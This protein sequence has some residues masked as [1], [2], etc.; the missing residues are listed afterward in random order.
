MSPIERRIALWLVK[1]R[2]V[3]ALLSVLVVLLSASGARFLYLDTDYKIF[4]SEENPYR[5]AH[6]YI[7]DTYV[8]NQDVMF[9]IVPRNGQVFTKQS[10][11]LIEQLTAD[12]WTLP[13][14]SRVNSVTNFQHTAA[15]GD[16]LL[17]NYLVEDAHLLTPEDITRVGEIANSEKS[18][19]NVL[20]AKDHS[21]SGVNV[22]F[23][24]PDSSVKGDDWSSWEGFKARLFQSETSSHRDRGLVDKE[25][26]LAATSLRDR[27]ESLYPE[28][29]IFLF[30]T[31][32]V[33]DT[34]NEYALKDGKTL[35]PLMFVVIILGLLLFLRLASAS[36]LG[37]TTGTLSV[38]LV[39][40]TSILMAL[41]IAG[42]FGSSLDTVSSVAPTIILTL[43]IAD[44]VHVLFNFL[45]AQAEGKSR[46]EAI[47]DSLTIN[48][49][50]IFLTS[51]T[52]AI[53]FFS[54]NFSDSPPFRSFGSITG[55]GIIIAFLLC[56]FLLPALVTLLPVTATAKHTRNNK[57]Y[58]LV[59]A[60]WVI[61]HYRI[62]FVSSLVFVAISC[63]FI[64]RNQ[65]NDS[66]LTY[67][68]DGSELVQAADLYEKHIG[69]FENLAYSIS[70]G[71]EGGINE[72]AFLYQLDALCQWLEE[73]PKVT[74]VS[75]Y[76]DIIKRL[77]QNMH[78]DDPR[79]YKIPESRELASQYLL[80]YE[81]SLPFGLDLNTQLDTTKSSVRV[82]IVRYHELPQD[83]IVDE[84][85]FSEYIAREFP[86]LKATPGS[87]VPLMF[88]QLGKR[89]IES[90]FIGNVLA[91]VL[92]S[93]ILIVALRSVGFGLLSLLP[94]IV[95]TLVALGAWGAFSGQVNM[96]VAVVFVIA[97]GIVVDDTVHFLSKYL[98]S[99]R[100]DGMNAK[101]AIRK[102]FLQVGYPL[103]ITTAVLSSGF[104]VLTAS[105][106][107]L[108]SIMGG[109]VGLTI[110]IA[111]VLDL[112]FL[113]S[114][115]LV[116][117]DCYKFLTAKRCKS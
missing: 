92:I 97:L 21:L 117:N 45:D 96:V 106:F 34:F 63:L 42:W 111:L 108:N 103:L 2:W 93:L 54:L 71:E 78:G 14:S 47:E 51:L 87:S 23:E 50:P 109:L 116:S 56:L 9:L 33:N 102:T 31:V 53:G 73:Q 65:M 3:L 5:V 99:R 67:F 114:L 76:T 41:G 8:E 58:L 11:Q 112:L 18:L 25:I 101:D 62:I 60:D 4:F 46:V 68:D 83:L 88:A 6:E 38:L 115:L 10:L 19:I 57:P 37:A 105:P 69:G 55:S 89:N 35:L 1:Y 107:S 49:Q 64:T 48:L 30:G 20:L 52:T 91:L 26:V 36:K 16:D 24:T 59:L 75:C 81:L 44:C 98:R 80:L 22:L 70:S 28:I 86:A 13:Y 95:P 12:A 94:N 29:D 32:T 61:S 85:R 84:K 79:W 90:M 27:F 113:P 7:E 39:V 15:D 110:I 82:N 43:A 104:F 66:I 77:N 100:N 74:S 17:V 72:P 40:V